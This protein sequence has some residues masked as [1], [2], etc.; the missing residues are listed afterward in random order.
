MVKITKA[1]IIRYM[2]YAGALS[3]I[4]A[5]FV[6]QFATGGD[7]GSALKSLGKTNLWFILAAIVI[8]VSTYFTEAL[9][10]YLLAKTLGKKP[11]FW[12]MMLIFFIGNFFSNVT[13]ATSGGKPFQ[14]YFLLDQGFSVAEGTV[15][16]IARGIISVSTRIFLVLAVAVAV[17]FGFDS[18]LSSFIG[19]TFAL[20]LAMMIALIAIGIAALLNPKFFSFLVNMVS[21][22]GFVR[23]LV[24]VSTVDECIA[25]GYRFL[26]SVKNSSRMIFGGNKVYLALTIFTSLVSWF[27][28]KTVP[29]FVLLS[30]GENIPLMIVVATS[31]ISQLIT[32][33]VPTPGASGGVEI[34]LGT[35][36]KGLV[37][38]P[39]NLSPFVLVYRLI[40]YHLNMLVGL[41]IAFWAL[42]KKVKP[43]ACAA[44][45]NGDKTSASVPECEG[46]TLK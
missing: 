29:F 26:D 18:N 13:P 24:K 45:Q 19:W 33:W 28:L 11:S 32:I 14:I 20:T 5:L 9:Q 17:L 35:L 6:M 15:M 16:V 30:F 36:F 1:Q 44:P 46:C 7:F 43:A 8:N 23:K 21:K 40:D 38:N 37:A 25:K 39:G 31:I 2:L 10:L 41:P 3:I 34:G 27:L 12:G 42:G 4:A 22:I